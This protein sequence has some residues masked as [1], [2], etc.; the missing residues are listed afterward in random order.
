MFMWDKTIG[1]L[2]VSIYKRT[3]DLC[4]LKI[5]VIFSVACHRYQRTIHFI[6]SIEAAAK[7]LFV[8]IVSDIE[9]AEET[10]CKTYFIGL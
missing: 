7:T 2:W 9:S 3:L 6:G 10:A 5:E 1:L 4:C 8:L